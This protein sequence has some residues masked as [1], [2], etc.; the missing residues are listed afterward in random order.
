MRFAAKIQGKKCILSNLFLQGPDLEAAGLA[1][2]GVLTPATAMG[3]VLA[4]RLRAAGFKI[5]A[6][7]AQEPSGR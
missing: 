5:E 1:K 4:D 2:G 6:L 7:P 3:L